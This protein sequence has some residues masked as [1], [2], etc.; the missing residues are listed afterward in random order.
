MSRG[1]KLSLGLSSHDFPA[2]GTDTYPMQGFPNNKIV[3]E[4]LKTG[5][6][7]GNYLRLRY[8]PLK[9]LMNHR[10]NASLT[11]TLSVSVGF[12]PTGDINPD[13]TT[14][15]AELWWFNQAGSTISQSTSRMPQ[16]NVT[17]H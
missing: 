3:M 4:E 15:S 12:D 17:G 14:T 6:K 8:D 1:S 2:C 10:G 9:T 13:V 11:G 16:V 5:E 7:C